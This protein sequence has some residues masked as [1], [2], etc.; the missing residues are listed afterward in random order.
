MVKFLFYIRVIPAVAGFIGTLWL[1]W[2]LDGVLWLAA[3]M[4]LNGFLFGATVGL[5]LAFLL[6]S[7]G[8]LGP[9]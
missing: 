4:A 9:D 8:C 1:L 7:L 2:P 3:A 5:L 6:D